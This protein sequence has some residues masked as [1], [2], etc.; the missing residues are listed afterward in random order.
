EAM[1][2]AAFELTKTR[3]ERKML[4]VVTDGQPQSAPACRSVIDLCERSDVEVIGIGVE[5]TAVSGLFQKNIVIDDA[6]ALQRTLFKLM[7]RSLTAFAA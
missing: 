4:I 5:T 3:E 1:W 6:A 2:Y 7:E